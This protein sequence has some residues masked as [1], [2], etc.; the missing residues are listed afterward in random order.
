MF[1]N[2]KLMHL[3]NSN[4]ISNSS[5]INSKISLHNSKININ[6][7]KNSTTTSIKTSAIIC[8]NN[9]ILGITIHK[10]IHLANNNSSR[11]EVGTL[12]KISKCRMNSSS[13][14]ILHLKHKSSLLSRNRKRMIVLIIMWRE[15]L[16]DAKTRKIS[17]L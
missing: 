16:K 5:R 6:N 8:L 3:H 11:V 12:V 15:P 10:W 13:L 7:H 9:R 17:K 4:S 1:S 2:L 14:K